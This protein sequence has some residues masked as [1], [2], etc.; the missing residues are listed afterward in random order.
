MMK[1]ISNRLSLYVVLLAL[2][3][4]PQI[5]TAQIY[6]TDTGSGDVDAGFRKTGTYQE[7]YEMV[8]YL[9]NLTN[10]LAL[11]AGTTTNLQNFSGPLATMC[12]DGLGNLQWSVFSTYDNNDTQTPLGF[13]PGETSWYT[14]ARTNV[15][16]QTVPP[17]RI[18]SNTDSDLTDFIYEAQNTANI[19]SEETAQYGSGTNVDNNTLVVLESIATYAAGNFTLSDLIGD[20]RN[21]AK[22]DFY[23]EA[24]DYSVENTTSN[25]FT[26]A[27]V[28][29]FYQNVPTSSSDDGP[30]VDPIT[31]LTNGSS[32][33]VGYFTLNPN[34][35]MT[36]TRAAA[37]TAP[38][39]G[40]VSATLTNG[41]APLTVVFTNTA[42]GTITG[43]IWN[44]G[45]GTIITNTTGANVTNTYAAGGDYTVTLTVTGPAGSSTNILTNYIV[46]SPA[47][48]LNNL[49]YFNGKLT[50]G[51]T[52]GPVNVR[53]R[54]LTSTNLA[55]PLANWTPVL[56]NTIPSNG[57]YGYT[58]GFPTN[59]AAYFRLV[60]P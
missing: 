53:Y 60:S 40:S 47:P 16:H 15:N 2:L 24:I 18:S 41:F 54:I 19:V 55:L 39:A 1:S 58:N 27:S 38:A 17:I 22:G 46:S 43:W 32:Y 10:F 3:A 6:F 52:N 4:W 9:G 11:P 57:F 42:S 26:S 56:T 20:Q 59:L 34:G 12:P 45:N 37:V 44:F 5:T 31:G 21:S 30:Y 25:K 48:K 50:L 14:L 35:T 13:F 8:A 49:T 28:S 51:G 23:G 7:N 29:D 33:Y 36:F